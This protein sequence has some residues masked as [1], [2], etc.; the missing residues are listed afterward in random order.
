MENMDV[1]DSGD[2]Y[3]IN[4]ELGEGIKVFDEGGEMVGM[5]GWG[6]SARD[7]D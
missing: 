1:V 4:A 2:S 7:A 6:E 3:A 5:A